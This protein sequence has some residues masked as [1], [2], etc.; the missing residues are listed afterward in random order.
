MKSSGSLGCN[1]L[2]SEISDWTTEIFHSHRSEN[3]KPYNSR[4][5]RPKRV[6]ISTIGVLCSERHCVSESGQKCVQ[7][8]EEGHQTWASPGASVRTGRVLH[9]DLFACGNVS[10]ISI[11]FGDVISQ[12]NSARNSTSS[13]RNK[14]RLSRNI[15]GTRLTL[16]CERSIMIYV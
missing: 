1:A 11:H 7:P 5:L 16:T 8:C 3:P 13:A 2:Y 12:Y 14:I 9:A 15:T 10:L 4:S 6:H